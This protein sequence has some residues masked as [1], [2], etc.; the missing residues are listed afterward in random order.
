[1]VENKWGKWGWAGCLSNDTG[2]RVEVDVV[3]MG[4]LWWD[5]RDELV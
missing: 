5:C 1:M 3:G 2:V 4:Y